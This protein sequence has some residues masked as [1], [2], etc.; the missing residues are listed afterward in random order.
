MK[1]LFLAAAL[2][3]GLAVNAQTPATPVPVTTQTTPSTA[4][5]TAAQ[6]TTTTASQDQD[7]AFAKVQQAEIAPAVLK[8]AVAKYQGYS[9]V[10]AL[11]A[12]DGSEYK[13]VLTKD[14]KDVA[15]YYKNN[16]EFI[17]EVAA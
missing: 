11:K 4:P 16:G 2:V 3:L 9:L 17:K 14:G 8:E 12:E 15:A 10:E 13:L 1:N 6:V 5:A 7:K